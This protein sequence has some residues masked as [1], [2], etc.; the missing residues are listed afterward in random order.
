MNVFRSLALGACA[1]G[2]ILTGCD[3]ADPGTNDGPPAL[4][5]ADAFDFSEADF[6]QVQSRGMQAGDNFTNAAFRVG[7]V[8]LAVGLHLLIPHLSTQAALAAE[9]VIESGTWVWSNTVRINEDD[10]TF[11]LAGTPDGDGVD[12]SMR[13]SAADPVSGEVFDGFELYTAQTA[14][15]GRSGAWQLYYKVEGER[16]QVLDADFDADGEAQRRLAFHVPTGFGENGGDAV[17]YERDGNDRSFD[18]M[19]V[20]EGFEHAI[21][22]EAVSHTGSITATNYNGGERAC[23][24][25][26][27]E[28]VPCN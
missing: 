16:V 17:I 28:D 1:F 4:I 25:A 9:P 3:S 21:E 19:Q 22:W 12:W 23:W 5:A 10:V 20:A 24:D 6:P 26:D 2:L 13:I 11:A 14:F 27:L 7:A 15:D 18:W 8:N